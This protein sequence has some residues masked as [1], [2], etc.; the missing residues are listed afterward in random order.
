MYNFRDKSLEVKF[1]GNMNTC[2]QIH[3]TFSDTG[4][5]VICGS[6]DRKVYIWNGTSDNNSKRDKRGYEYFEGNSHEVHG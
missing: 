4:K 6:E 1:K 5:Y 3:A 2:S